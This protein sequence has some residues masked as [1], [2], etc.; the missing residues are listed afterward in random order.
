MKGETVGIETNALTTQK[1]MLECPETCKKKVNKIE[2]KVQT[3]K[4]NEKV[5]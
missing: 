1:P 4:D 2:T 3:I 5:E